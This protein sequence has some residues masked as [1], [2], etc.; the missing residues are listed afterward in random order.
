VALV[1]IGLPVYNG[2]RY[3]QSAIESALAQ[4]HADLE[5]IVSDNASTDR[6]GE[7]AG[8][9]VSRDKRVRYVRNARNI[10]PVGNFNNVFQMARGE[11]FKWLAYDDVCLPEMIERCVAVLEADQTVVMATTRFR[12][13][14]ADDETLGEQAYSI[15]LAVHRPHK[16]LGNLMSTA[17]GHAMLY[18]VIRAATLSQTR[19]MGPY[20]GS[21]RALLAEL[22]LLGRIVELPEV[23]WLSR[24]H[25]QRSP[26]VLKQRDW[27]PS[28]KPAQVR[29]LAIVRQMAHVLL[30]VPLSPGER[31]RCI[32]QLVRSVAA[33]SGQLIPVFL[34][35]LYDTA[36]YRVGRTFKRT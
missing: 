36:R 17:H 35:E 16:R 27:D 24:D 23:S 30:T 20:Q 13:I 21:D 1:S 22:C 14:G 26:A 9:F 12:E 31:A 10:G 25:P 33:R 18:G 29:H 3:L 4:T 11:Y 6:T 2:E 32:A 8:D 5:L 34:A 7:I 28:R 15:D 19:L